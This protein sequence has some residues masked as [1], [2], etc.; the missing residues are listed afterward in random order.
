MIKLAD[1][2]TLLRERQEKLRAEELKRLEKYIV[3]TVFASTCTPYIAKVP[4]QVWL[5]APAPTFTYGCYGVCVHVRVVATVCVRLRL[6]ATVYMCLH[7][8]ATVFVR[9]CLVAR[10]AKQLKKDEEARKAAEKAA[11]GRIAPRD[12]FRAET[13]KYSQ[14]DDNVRMEMQ[15]AMRWEINN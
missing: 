10:Q 1:R 5:L 7:V 3:E 2:E 13:D 12:M 6:V 15:Q 14:F 4:V 8:V 9:L 11:Q